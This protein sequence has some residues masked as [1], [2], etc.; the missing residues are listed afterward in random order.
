MN[1]RWLIS[2]FLLFI[3]QATFSQT[4]VREV[5][6]NKSHREGTNFSVPCATPP[7]CDYHDMVGWDD[8]AIKQYTYRGHLDNISGP[9]VEFLN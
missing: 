3:A 7:L 9:V 4:I 5:V 8:S 6:P 1:F 2:G